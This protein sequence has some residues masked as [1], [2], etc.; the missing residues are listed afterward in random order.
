MFA[1]KLPAFNETP[2]QAF[3]ETFADKMMEHYMD[4]EGNYAKTYLYNF[5]DKTRLQ[6]NMGETL[7]ILCTPVD[8]KGE[9]LKEFDKDAFEDSISKASVMMHNSLPMIVKFLADKLPEKL[10]ELR[11]ACHEISYNNYNPKFISYKGRDP[12]NL[13]KTYGAS[14]NDIILHLKPIGKFPVC[15][16][17]KEGMYTPKQKQN[18]SAETPAA[19]APVVE[20][21]ALK[22]A[23]EAAAL[24][25]AAET[26]VSNLAVAETSAF[27]PAK[28][29]MKQTYAITAAAAGGGGAKKLFTGK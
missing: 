3:A 16:P 11:W 29:S 21:A 1:I 18:K 12:A 24:K 9:I 7:K 25:P 28:P 2:D 6:M 17:L 4:E 13:T 15:A 26:P 14:V 10:N 27:K 19:E 8:D 5:G 22:P 23:A 20:A